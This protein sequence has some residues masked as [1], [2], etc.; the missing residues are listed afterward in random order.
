[1]ELL[2]TQEIGLQPKGQ[3]EW[4]VDRETAQRLYC[5]RA[6]IEPRIGIAGRLGLKK[7]RAK[8]DEGDL[9]FG[10]KAAV[11]FNFKKLTTC[12]ASEKG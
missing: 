6:A 8:T 12:W 7:S 11:G 2:K 3:S 10:Y 4:E 5:R 1:M 9:I